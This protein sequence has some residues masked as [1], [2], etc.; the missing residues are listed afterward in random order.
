MR[1][2]V[3]I[4]FLAFILIITHDTSWVRKEHFLVFG[5]RKRLSR[6]QP[7]KTASMSSRARVNHFHNY[8][9]GVNGN[10]L[11]ISAIS[12]NKITDFT[13]F[14][15]ERK[16]AD[17]YSHGIWINEIQQKIYRNKVKMRKVF[18]FGEK[19][20]VFGGEIEK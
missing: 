1:F 8:I 5:W 4:I 12:G 19:V 15:I 9:S 20:G 13:Y 11:K 2:T 14:S 6:F 10:F 18:F 16:D 17:L 7:S 3:E